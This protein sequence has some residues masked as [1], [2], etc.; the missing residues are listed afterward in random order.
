MSIHLLT[1]V[2][3]DKYPLSFP[4]PPD[5]FSVKETLSKSIC[6]CG[7][8]GEWKST[9]LLARDEFESHIWSLPIDYD[10]VV[11]EIINPSV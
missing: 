2:K 10:T 3:K 9:E 4:C 5:K 8:I 11:I 6:S 1:I 7:W